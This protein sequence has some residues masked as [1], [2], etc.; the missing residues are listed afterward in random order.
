MK[1][2]K[3]S[4]VPGNIIPYPQMFEKTFDSSQSLAEFPITFHREG[5]GYFLNYLT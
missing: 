4:V 3:I 5:Y 1:I 2:Y